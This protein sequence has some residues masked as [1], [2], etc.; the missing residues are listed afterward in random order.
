MAK[1][2]KLPLLKNGYWGFF[3][4]IHQAVNKLKARKTQFLITEHFV[5][6]T[7]PKTKI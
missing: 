6:W 5:S 2:V 3:L 4:N 7:I 1:F